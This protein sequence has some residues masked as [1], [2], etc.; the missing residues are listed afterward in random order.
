MR[1]VWGLG[2]CRTSLEA[3]PW[4]VWISEVGGLRLADLMFQHLQLLQPKFFAPASQL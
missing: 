4:Y 1:N 3:R 2:Q